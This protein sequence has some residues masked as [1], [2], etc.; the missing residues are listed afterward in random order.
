MSYK[1]TGKITDKNSGQ[2]ISGLLVHAFDE[3]L[4]NDDDLGT[5]T[6]DE[7]GTFSIEY[8]EEQFKGLFD[9]AA[10]VY[11][12][13][14]NQAGKMILSTKAESRWDAEKHEHF[15][16]EVEGAAG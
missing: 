3:D 10:D 12:K 14:Y 15:D 11:L 2:P 7:G 16:L 8:T 5:A 13:V 4:F 6:T 1:I 9:D